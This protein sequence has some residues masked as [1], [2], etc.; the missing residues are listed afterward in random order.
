MSNYPPGAANDSSAPY[1]E[2]LTRYS[3]I[4]VEAT[5]DI[6][7]IIEVEVEVDEDGYPILEDLQEVVKKAF[8]KRFNIENVDNVLNDIHI[9]GWRFK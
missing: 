9:W 2:P 7:A 1:N 3:N 6:S 8:I 4:I 5:A